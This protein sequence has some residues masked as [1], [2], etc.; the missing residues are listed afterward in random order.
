MNRRA[1]ALLYLDGGAGLAAGIF[2]LVLH[3]WLA[4]LHHVAPTTVLAI[5]AVNLAYGCY[6]GTLALRNALGHAPSRFAID[7][8]IAGNACWPLVC[9]GVLVWAWSS[10]SV[11]GVAHLALEAVFVGGL[12]V[13]EYLWLRPFTSPRSS[14]A[15]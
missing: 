9:V 4:R 11:Y 13:A 1:K 2:M 6:S 14:H 3:E 12:A 5:G 7:V 8:L 15:H 10:I